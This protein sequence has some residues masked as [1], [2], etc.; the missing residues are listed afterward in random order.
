MW[1]WG[2][3]NWKMN[4]FISLSEMCIKSD[5]QKWFTQILINMINMISRDLN[6]VLPQSWLL[7]WEM[8]CS[9]GALVNHSYQDPSYTDAP[10]APHRWAASTMWQAVTPEPHDP[11][12][13]FLR[14]TCDISKNCFSFSVDR[15]M[16]SSSR[17]PKK[18]MHLEPGM[19]PDWT[20]GDSRVSVWLLYTTPEELHNYH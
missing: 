8:T 15:N 2:I 14:S 11:H 19:W 13:G 3:K 16:P 1:E 4:L 17:N 6:L 7:T 5:S 10:G 20:P 18:G 12:R 9:G